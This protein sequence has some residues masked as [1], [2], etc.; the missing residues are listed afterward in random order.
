MAEPGDFLAR[1]SRL[2]REARAAVAE[3]RPAAADPAAPP[4]AAATAPPAEAQLPELPPI[5]SL[6]KDSDYTP[7]LRPG[8]PEA[9][10]KAA[11]RKLWQ[12]DPVFANLDGLL[13]YGEDFGEPFRAAGAIATVYRVLKGMP[14]A[15]E[16]KEPDQ[17]EGAPGA[18][19]APQTTA[20]TD[21]PAETP[22]PAPQPDDEKQSSPR[23]ATAG[24]ERS[25]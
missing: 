11:L 24:P 3:R 14:D 4:P 17:A 16:E 1:W 13:E 2:K 25:G 12:S 9:L 7:F 15:T 10:R 22:A 21:E 20:A 23:P 5:D 6:T 19:T 18:A 8:V